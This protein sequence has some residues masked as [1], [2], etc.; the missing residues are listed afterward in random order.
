MAS[1]RSEAGSAVSRTAMTEPLW[2][3]SKASL[4]K[5]RV[6]VVEEERRTGQDSAVVSQDAL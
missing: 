5:G 2:M 4:A 6:E 3:S 1:W